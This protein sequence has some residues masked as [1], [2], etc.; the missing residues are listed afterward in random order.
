MG[1]L[2]YPARQRVS[3]YTAGG[4]ALAC[5]LLFGIPA[6]RH[7][8]RRTIGLLV[9]LAILTGGMLACG[10][11]GSSSGGSGITANPGTTTGI[12]TVTV[13][14]TSGTMTAQ[15]VVTLDVQ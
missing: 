4:P 3:W 7:S 8:W 10:G 6:L 13:T 1:A 2:A 5:L 15:G 14:A 9:L 12:Y 11:G